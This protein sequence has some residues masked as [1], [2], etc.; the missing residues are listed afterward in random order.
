MIYY[1]SRHSRGFSLVELAVVMAIVGLVLG[2]AMLTLSAQ[3]DTRRFNE[4]QQQ[5]EQAREL[6]IA[7]AIKNRRMPCPATLAAG[8]GDEAPVGGGTCTSYYGGFLP[9]RA[10]GFQSVDSAGYAIDAWNNRIRYALSSLTWGTSGGFSTAHV[11]GNAAVQWSL[12]NTP[13]DLVICSTSPLVITATACDALTNIT[14]VGVV[15]AIV[16]STGKNGAT[17]GTGTNEARN[18][19]SN[20]LFVYRQ[21]DSIETATGEFDDQM[22]WIPASLLYSRMISA[23][24]LP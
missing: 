22:I 9:G 19:D 8:T 7:F 15:S 12:S 14:N 23:G 17:G 2:S 10:I 3:Q 20:Q 5:L 13:G 6:L 18:L 16:F 21:Q 11:S 24:I 1:A 4:T